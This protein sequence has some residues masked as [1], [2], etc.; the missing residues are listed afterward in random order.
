MFLYKLRIQVSLSLKSNSFKLIQNFQSNLQ[1]LSHIFSF[2]ILVK[3]L[4]LKQKRKEKKIVCGVVE[5]LT[6]LHLITVQEDQP[7][8]TLL[9]TTVIL[10]LR[11][12]YVLG[13]YKVIF[14]K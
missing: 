14:Q 9:L 1:Q 12:M 5:M 2:S 13:V 4:L 10:S 7:Q 6:Q 8:Q 3:L 11:E